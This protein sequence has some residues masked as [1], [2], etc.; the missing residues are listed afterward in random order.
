MDQVSTPAFSE[1]V[2]FIACTGGQGERDCSS[3]DLP[4]WIPLD[5]ILRIQSQVSLIWEESVMA[6]KMGPSR[7][8]KP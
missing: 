7:G 8:E 6:Q 3:D 1:D 4:F 2:T 5:L